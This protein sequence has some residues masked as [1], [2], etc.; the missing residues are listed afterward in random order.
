[1]EIDFTDGFDESVS[2]SAMNR[3]CT[4]FYP[5]FFP[6]NKRVTLKRLFGTP[7]LNQLAT[8]GGDFADRNRGSVTMD[9]VPYFVNSTTMFRL[10]ADFT[11]TT[12]G[13]VQGSGKVS[14]PHNG[15][16][17]M[18]LVPGG[19]GYI[20]NKDTAAF[21]EISDSD[22]IANGQPQVAIFVHGYFMAVTDSKKFIISNLRDGTAWSALDFGTAEADPDK[23]VSLVNYNN[24]AYLFGFETLEG[25]EDIGGS[26]FPFVSNEL[27]W[28]KGCSAPFS[29]V[30]S[31]NA[32]MWVGAGEEEDPAIW[33]I[34]GTELTKIS[35]TGVDTLLGA[36]TPVQMAQVNAYAYS[37]ENSTF[38]CWELPL[39]TVCYGLDSGK[40]HKR[41]SIVTDGVGFKNAVGWRATG[42]V[43]AYSKLICFDTQDGKVGDVSDDFFDEYGE[44][45]QREVDVN[46]LRAENNTMV[47][48]RIEVSIDAGLGDSTT[49][50]PKIWIELTRDGKIYG[51][52]KIR[53]MGTKGKTR[54]RPVW[55][56]NG[57]FEQMV[58]MRI[59][60]AAKVRPVITGVTAQIGVG[61]T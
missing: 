4:N 38:V 15:T 58:G 47:V 19:K 23:L 49:P 9:G 28:D 46:K 44:N 48:P 30:K 45:I 40:W 54:H 27:I 33:M 51:P 59:A 32:F 41:K 50:D 57:K 1:M 2:H 21:A 43:T 52:A 6:V 3:Q 25:V 29:V 14:M 56:Q 11:A 34:R 20:F 55:R 18:V 37:Q 26:D 31:S 61:R 16:Q 39:E 10:N 36:L 24:E 22:F 35:N 60:T 7:G 17:V 12:L 5:K 13:T 53:S 42:L 8:T